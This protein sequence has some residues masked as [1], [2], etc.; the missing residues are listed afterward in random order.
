MKKM[1]AFERYRFSESI[2]AEVFKH[3]ISQKKN[4]TFGLLS[5]VDDWAMILLSIHAAKY[6]YATLYHTHLLFSLI[7]YFIAICIIGARQRGLAD[8][9]HVATHHCFASNRYVN[10]FLGTFASGYLIFQ[11]FHGYQIS[12]VRHHHP[13]LGTSKDPDYVSNSSFRRTWS[14]LI[15]SCIQM[16]LKESGICGEER[17]TKNVQKYLRN[18]F[19]PGSSWKY[20]VYLLKHRICSQVG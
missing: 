8:C 18:L 10:H 11:S 13:H 4:N 20:F 7:V 12:H 6:T 16:S 17:T 9:L 5:L 1:K 3:T 14:M 19:T 2:R 15:F